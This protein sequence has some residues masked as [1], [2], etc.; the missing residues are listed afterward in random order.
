MISRRV[1]GVMSHVSIRKTQP[2]KMFFT[3]IT[4]CI[5]IAV[6][7]LLEYFAIG[8]NASP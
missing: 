2:K 8:L 6:V 1:G 3:L 4:I 7:R 5:L